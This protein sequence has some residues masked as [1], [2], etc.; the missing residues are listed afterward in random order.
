[1]DKEFTPVSIPTSLYKKIEERIKGTDITS[2][3]GYISKV[4]RE[5]FSGEVTSAGVFS[6]EEE[7]KVKEKLKALGYID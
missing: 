5:H 2:V 3:A 1:M 7:E 6:E 4:L